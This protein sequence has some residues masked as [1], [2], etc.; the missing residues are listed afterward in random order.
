M[1]QILPEDGQ[2]FGKLDGE[3]PI[4]YKPRI[5]R[6]YAANGWQPLWNPAAVKS[7]SAA[8][9]G[10]AADGLN[11]DDYR[12]QETTPYLG[13]SAQTPHSLGE[14]ASVDILLTEACLRALDNLEYGKVDPDTLDADSNYA[15]AR[16][17]K[18]RSARLVSWIKQGR[19]EEAF[20]EARPKHDRYLWLKSA[21]NHYRQ[22]QAAGGWPLI[23]AGKSLK[24]GKTDGRVPLIR[25]RLV[26]TGDLAPNPKDSAVANTEPSTGQADAAAAQ[27][28]ELPPTTPDKLHHFDKEL[29]Q[30][31]KKFQERHNLEPDGVIGPATLA[32]MNVTVDV[33]IDQLR[34]SM[35]RQRWYFPKGLDEYLL[36]D[37]AGFHV[38]WM[39]GQEALWQERVQVGQR[40]T[41]T[42]IFRDQIEHIIFN[43]TWSVPPGINRRTI[44]PSLKVDASYL[45]KKGYELLDDR[46]KTI[47]PRSVD[48]EILS[49]MPF[50]VRQPP[51]RGNALGLVKFMFPNKF[52]VFLHDTNHRDLFT[53]QERT[54]SNGCIRLQD[55]FYLAEHL[56]A[57]QG[58]D[59]AR[60][61]RVL[62]TGKTTQTNLERPLPILVQYSTAVATENQVSFREDI[63]KRDEDLLAALNGPFQ[64]PLSELPKEAQ[65]RVRAT[66]I[67]A[68]AST[69]N[70]IAPEAEIIGDPVSKS[71][72]VG[73][74]K[75]P[76]YFDI[77]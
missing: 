10:L 63:Y 40:L 2:R 45:D 1:R 25:R 44:L 57:R 48:W 23:P 77:P 59:R 46:G 62:A 9:S 76:N 34:L 49:K 27:A 20:D 74:A 4:Y 24:P 55:P 16:D 69:A 66:L 14:L 19:I 21:L 67:S 26:I 13:D 75:A 65:A 30:A 53:K 50:T 18:D 38:Y 52:S 51:G 32:M 47:D 41:K 3:G 60:I 12:F 39:K 35:E 43:P 58:W 56:L 33:R 73:S 70:L 6:L 37:V 5:L 36:I 54:T 7:L 17:G 71:V 11:P 31:V 28:A 68:S 29:E 64:L 22:I 72:N 15:P 42:P 61:D 8:L